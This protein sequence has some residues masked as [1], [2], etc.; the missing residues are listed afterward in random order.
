MSPAL[1][2]LFE[3][4]KQTSTFAGVAFDD[5][6]ATNSDGDNALH[7]AARSNDLTAAQLLIEAEI[8]VNQ[9]GDLGRTPLHEACAVGDPAMVTFLVS[10]GAD[11]YAKTEGDIPFGVARLNGRG[12]I[13][14]LLRPLMDAAQQVDPQIWVRVR[15]EHL[16]REIRRL[17]ALLASGVRPTDRGGSA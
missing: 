15:I 9:R 16:K 14:A 12:D 5:V 10:K 6:N 13:C 3:K 8:E 2:M 7:W 4:L 1:V 17:E 11:L